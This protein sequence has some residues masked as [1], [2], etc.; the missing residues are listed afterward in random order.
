MEKAGR[1]AAPGSAAGSDSATPPS[2]RIAGWRTCVLHHPCLAKAVS[3]VV[4]RAAIALQIAS[5]LSPPFPAEA[6]HQLGGSPEDAGCVV[7]FSTAAQDVSHFGK[8]AAMFTA[9]VHSALMVE[10][11]I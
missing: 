6:I 11:L 3:P 9:F 5:R 4:A 1:R 2:V 7:E 10:A 8:F